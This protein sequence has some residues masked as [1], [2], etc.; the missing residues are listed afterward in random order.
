[1]I[2]NLTL[3]QY[4]SQ[5]T[6]LHQINPKVKLI[7]NSLYVFLL[8]FVNSFVSLGFCVISILLIYFFCKFSINLIFKNL[9][10]IAIFL[11]IASF[12]NLFF[13][14]TGKIIFEFLFLKITTDALILTMVLVLRIFLLITGSSLLIYTTL[15]MDLTLAIEEIL[16][17]LKKF[18]L[19]ID[20][21]A[22]MMSIA[23]RFIPLLLEESSLIISAQKSRGL[24]IYNQNG[25]LKKVKAL[26]IFFIPLLVT[27]FKRASELAISMEARCFR[28]GEIRTR[29]KSLK[30]SKLDFQFSITCVIFLILVVVLNLLF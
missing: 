9:K 16:R 28:V 6:F 23:L 10:I 25:I 1:M 15:P 11:V 14:K 12:F 4:V 17:P 19:P 5:N 30:Y 7:F 18:K 27:S 20:E 29:Y 21:I 3:G 24:D 2:N 26:S 13:V 8:F 22:I